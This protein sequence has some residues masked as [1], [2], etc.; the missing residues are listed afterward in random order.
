MPKLYYQHPGRD[1]DKSGNQLW[2]DV[3]AGRLHLNRVT[4]STLTTVAGR[5]IRPISITRERRR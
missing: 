3:I 5:E 1:D 2:I 4:V